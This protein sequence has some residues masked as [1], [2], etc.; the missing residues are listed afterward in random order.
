MPPEFYRIH[1]FFYE[2]QTQAAGANILQ[3]PAAELAAIDPDPAIFQHNFE[4]A[5]AR[6]ILRRVNAAEGYLD[7]LVC[8]SLIGVANN[9]RQRFVDGQDYCPALRVG[10]SQHLREGPQ[11]IPDDTK[12]VRIAGQFHS[13]KQTSSIHTCHVTDT[14][15]CLIILQILQIGAYLGNAAI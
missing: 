15:S 2:M 5:S 14:P 11:S 4:T 6:S 9:I 3:V 10:K 13:E 8:S 7:G 1:A 12:R